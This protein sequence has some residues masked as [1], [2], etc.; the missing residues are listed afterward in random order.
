MTFEYSVVGAML[1]EPKCIDDVL[2]VVGADDFSN[3]LCK[4]A[5]KAI[6][7]LRNEAQPIDAL[8][9]YN[10]AKQLDGNFTYEFAKECMMLCPTAENATEHAKIVKAASDTDKLTGIADGINEDV[11]NRKSP[12]SIVS[13][14]RQNLEIISIGTA[15]GIANSENL[16]NLW[17]AHDT[18]V[19]ADPES[20]YCKT[21]YSSL[22]IVLGGGLFNTG[23]YIIGARPGMGKTTL[24][25]SLAENIASRDKAVLFISLE[26]NKVQI[27]AKRIAR[28]SGI[29]YTQ[30]MTGVYKGQELHRAIETN[31]RLSKTPFYLSDDS[32]CRVSDIENMAHSIK[33]LSCIIVDYFGLLTAEESSGV[34]SRY[35]ETTDISKALKGLAKRLNIPLI[36]LAQLNRNNTQKNDKRPT[37]AD[38]RDT[39]ALEQD[40]D[41]VILLHRDD[42]YKQHD[43][44]YEPPE[45]E[46]IELNV[47]KNRHGTCSVVKMI[48]D[49]ATGGIAEESLRTDEPFYMASGDL[50]F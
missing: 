24:G 6:V 8:L 36:V 41:C 20:A 30:L 2:A 26:M 45:I 38:L 47:A 13:S 39:G 32:L 22:D 17:K 48:W 40:A 28:K 33:N 34:K 4:A 19:K 35:E 25:I 31:D 5:V 11:F 46:F 9:I 49:G 44:N 23:L 27:M 18:Q 42:Y 15:N 29:G 12:N 37:L 43:E 7:Q 14:L 16:A 1:I 10:R 50:P 21:G 3:E